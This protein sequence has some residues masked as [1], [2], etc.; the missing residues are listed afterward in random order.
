MEVSEF[1]YVSVGEGATEALFTASIDPASADPK[2]QIYS[3]TLE[4]V[5]ICNT[6][7][8]DIT[9]TLTIT[10]GTNSFNILQG[11]TIPTSTTL[12]V[13]NGVPFVYDA[14]YRVNITTGA[15]HTC[16]VLASKK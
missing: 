8:E 13:L 2:L 12:D 11:C 16:D 3:S 6:D 10:D 9:I 14:R 4:R 15:G 7:N 5:L 1:K